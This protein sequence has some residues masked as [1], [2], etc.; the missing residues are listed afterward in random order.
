M[1]LDFVNQRQF[2]LLSLAVF[3]KAEIET[4]V[5]IYDLVTPS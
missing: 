1:C 2:N 5:G 3:Q 4:L